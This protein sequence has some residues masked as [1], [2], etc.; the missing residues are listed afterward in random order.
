[1]STSGRKTLEPED[2]TAIIDTREQRPWGLEP[3]KTE[4][5][6]LVTADYSV[7][8]LE[9]HIALERKELGDLLACIGLERERFEKEVKRLLSYEC[10]AV[11]VEA[12]WQDLIDAKWKRHITPNAAMGSVLGWM[13]LGLPFIFAGDAARASQ[14]AARMLF[15]AARRRWAELQSFKDGLRVV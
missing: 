4:R 1:M 3:L 13:A 8:G 2:I 9:T 6:K 14:A 15:I 12:S 11:I 10:R 7:K 5:G